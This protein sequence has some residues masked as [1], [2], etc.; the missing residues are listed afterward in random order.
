MF[1]DISI[2]EYSKFFP[3]WDLLIQFSENMKT[4]NYIE[5]AKIFFW[6]IFKN[7]INNHNKKFA[8][9]K[10]KQNKIWKAWDLK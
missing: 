7:N 4:D 6:F 10:L 5:K 1:T 3:K 9:N 8:L 2:Y